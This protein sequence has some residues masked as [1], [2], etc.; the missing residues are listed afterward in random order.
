MDTHHEESKKETAYWDKHE[1]AFAEEYYL[2]GMYQYKL[3]DFCQAVKWF[4]KAAEEQLVESY[5]MIGLFAEKGYGVKRDSEKAKEYFQLYIEKVDQIPQKTPNQLYRI[6]M[7]YAYGYGVEKNVEHAR[8]CFEKAENES[9]AAAY[10][11]GLIYRYNH[12]K[13]DI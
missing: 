10:E 12:K 11:L 4:V 8:D 7:C 2:Y 5:Y 1:A 3:L 6:G 9:G 13:T